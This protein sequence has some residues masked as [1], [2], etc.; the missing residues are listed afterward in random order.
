[1]SYKAVLYDMD[2]TVL[3]TLQDL[4]DAVNVSLTRFGLPPVTVDK[5]RRSVGNGARKLI[6]R[7]VPEGTDE[8]LTE[9]VLAFYKPWYDAHCRIRTRPY[10]GV[11]EL[12][13]RLRA[14]GVKQAIISNKPDPAVKELAEH[15]FP[16]LLETAVGESPTVRTKPD[17][18]A[19]LAAAAA[20]DVP[21]EDCVYVGD[22]E[23]DILAAANAGLDCIS[24]TWGFRS[25]ERLRAAGAE[26]VARD[27]P[28]LEAL[29][30]QG[31]KPRK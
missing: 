9:R 1:M 8:A 5:V 28:E 24:V 21:P 27:A 7:V 10:A 13:E 12:M 16:G 25:E 20:M 3:D 30:V 29:I 14:R 31:T 4:A 17:P 18:D 22:S 6:F 26:L 23:V 15:F 11:P 19:I 2:G